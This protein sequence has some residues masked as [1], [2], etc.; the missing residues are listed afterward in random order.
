MLA[1]LF[2]PVNKIQ[3]L[4]SAQPLPLYSYR[5]RL[6]VTVTVCPRNDYSYT[7]CC[8]KTLTLTGTPIT[9]GTINYTVTTVGGSGAPVSQSGTITVQAAMSCLELVTIPIIGLATT[10]NYSMVL[11]NGATQ[12]KVLGE[13]EFSAGNSDFLFSKAG[14]PS[15]SYTYKLMN[16]ATVVKEGTVVLP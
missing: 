12:I 10:G 3:T 9:E 6:Q 7:K 5:L 1:P 2:N 11:F 14:I 15:G 16:G 4:L 8:A 13:G